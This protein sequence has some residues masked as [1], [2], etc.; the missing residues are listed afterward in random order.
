[1]MFTLRSV[2]R[3]REIGQIVLF[4]GCIFEAV[5]DKRRTCASRKPAVQYGMSALAAVT[6]RACASSLPNLRRHHA[7][8]GHTATFVALPV[9]NDDLAL[10]S[11]DRS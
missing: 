3:G 7:V 9:L 5:R 11:E 8:V 1:M 10:S 2:S 4:Y 6:G